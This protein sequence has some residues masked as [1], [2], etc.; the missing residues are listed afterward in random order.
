MSGATDLDAMLA[1]LS[2]SQRP[3]TYTIVDIGEPS[4]RPT[5]GDGIE[6]L[7]N[8]GEGLTV[9]CT[10]DGARA[11]GWPVDFEAAWL[12]LDVHSALEAVGLTA[13]FATAL[14]AASIPCNVLAGFYHDHLLV[15]VERAAEAI[16]C[17]EG[18]R[19]H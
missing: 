3:A 9:V 16:A 10:V 18:L 13:A 8:E 6:A 5:I 14:G 4:E 11:H 15:P 19:S 17:L 7:I 2:V 1:S 12:T